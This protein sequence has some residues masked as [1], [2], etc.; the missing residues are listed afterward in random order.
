MEL[1]TI[2][3][4]FEKKIFRIPSY[5]RGFTWSNNKPLI[6]DSKDP[7]KNVTGQLKDLWDDIIN[8]QENSWHY[9]GLL[10]LAKTEL[11]Y[12]W[13]NTHEQY[14]IVDG[15]QRITS[16][17]ILLSILI[18]KADK[19][20]F[21]YGHIRNYTK[22]QY[23]KVV[24]AVDAY[25]F[26]YN[27]DNPSD[28][29]FKKYILNDN[30]ITDDT[31]ESV[32]TENLKC[33]KTFFDN[34][35]D[36]YLNRQMGNNLDE[37]SSLIKLFNKVTTK[38]KFNLYILPKDLNEYVVFETMNNRGKPLSELEKLKNRLMYLNY[39]LP[40]YNPENT[41]LEHE[42][43]KQL[44]KAQHS[45]TIRNID[46]AWITIYQSLGANKFKP[47]NDEEFVYNHWI[48]FFNEYDRSESKAYSNFL[49]DNYF[50]VA[51]IYSKAITKL[52]LEEYV[53]SL[54]E[55]SIIWN[56]LNYPQFFEN[57]E[58]VYAELIR[59]LNRVDFKSSFKPLVLAI[60]L[61]PN[62]EEY[63]PVIKLLE[64]FSFK[65]FYISD[66][67]SDTGNSKL[68]RLAYKIYKDGFDPKDAYI[69]IKQF[70]DLYYNFQYFKNQVA[71]LFKTGDKLGYYSWSGLQYF[72]FEYDLYLRKE[73]NV[74]DRSFEIN[75]DNFISKNSIEHVYPQSAAKSFEDYCSTYK[76]TDLIKAKIDYD[77][78]QNEWSA[79]ANIPYNERWAYCNSIGNLLA[80][81]GSLNASISN[82]KFAYKK[83]QGLKSKE[84]QNKGFIYDSMS[85]RIVANNNDWTPT[86]I[87]ERGKLMINYLWNKLNPDEQNALT[88]NDKYELLGLYFLIN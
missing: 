3:K 44:L 53:K 47:L 52:I 49:F 83:D 19:L 4:I 43:T 35:V 88:D 63:I 68:F 79:F 21:E 62:K 70:I 2:D 48:I 80:L 39:K 73:Q 40:L 1:Q 42:Q 76:K 22:S 72:L 84:H 5:Q 11:E 64:E 75:W 82:D 30:R 77:K 45:E 41:V 58:S 65:L 66:R 17:L 54:Q 71:E 69:E 29:Y 7:Y 74:T 78:I 87:I 15:Q 20:N 24:S 14:Y 56:K 86:T 59:T 25:I 28:K 81:N 38:L 13:L 9:T 27:T 37:V 16:I 51:N 10:T 31:K 61:K 33:A 12:E 26:G 46:T 55:S 18:E 23:L 85:A 36:L 50:T 34:C 57:T 60:L 32:Y 8:I 6:L 67:K